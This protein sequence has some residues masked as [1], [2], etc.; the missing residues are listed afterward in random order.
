VS[1]LPEQS[2]Q[3]RAGRDPIDALEF[4]TVE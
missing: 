2:L 4:G 3:V 1:Q